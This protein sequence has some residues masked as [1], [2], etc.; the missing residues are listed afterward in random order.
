MGGIAALLLQGAPCLLNRT[1]STVDPTVAR[2]TLRNLITGHAVALSSPAPDNTFG[3]GRA[4]ALSAIQSTLPTRKGSSTLTFD[5]NT[6]FGASINAAQL[7]F[8]DP[9]QCALTALNWTGDCGTS[10]G[11]SMTC[12]VGGP[13]AVTVSATNNAVGFSPTTDLKITVTDF[14]MTASPSSATVSAGQTAKYTVTVA[15]QG[16]PYRSAITL[17]CANLPP[18]ATCTFNPS[19]LTPGSAPAQSILTITTSSSA[20]TPP[21]GV[22]P[23][24]P[25]AAGARR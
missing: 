6:P 13:S 23:A 8:S 4:D 14:A 5:A 17:G 18:Q 11:A 24:H 19:T 12:P 22:T 2:T 15:P 21:A 9:N 3:V 25:F 10:A 16:G 7:G 1:T 20:L